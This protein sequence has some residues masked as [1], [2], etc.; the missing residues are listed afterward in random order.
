MSTN[1]CSTR[2]GIIRNASSRTSL[3][4]NCTSITV[5]LNI[6][7][8]VLINIEYFIDF[9]AI[10]EDNGPIYMRADVTDML[11]YWDS[12]VDSPAERREWYE[13]CVPLASQY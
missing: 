11:G 9:A 4:S 12:V 10:P 2:T 8:L 13:E 5:S 3:C 1:L 7:I 6:P